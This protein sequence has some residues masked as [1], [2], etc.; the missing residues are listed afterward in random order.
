M[1]QQKRSTACDRGKQICW[2]ARRCRGLTEFAEEYTWRRGSEAMHVGHRARMLVLPLICDCLV[3]VRYCHR[4]PEVPLLQAVAVQCIL[5][6]T[7]NITWRA[8]TEMSDSSGVIEALVLVLR[9]D[10]QE[11]AASAATAL[12]SLC[13]DNAINKQHVADAGAIPLLVVL[14]HT[15]DTNAQLQACLSLGACLIRHPYDG[16]CG[17]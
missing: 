15:P 17:F 3:V 6:L 9:T 7:T 4:L 12:A 11:A 1:R 14:L 13:V 5:A 2:V 10:N 8:I 16:S